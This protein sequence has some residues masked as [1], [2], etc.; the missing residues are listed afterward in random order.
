MQRPNLSKDRMDPSTGNREKRR[1]LGDDEEISWNREAPGTECRA[2][3]S[4]GITSPLGVMGKRGMVSQ[5]EE[6]DRATHWK[7]YSPKV[8]LAGGWRWQIPIWG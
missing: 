6:D 1:R 2:I 7:L 3:R 5:R 8:R 4:Y